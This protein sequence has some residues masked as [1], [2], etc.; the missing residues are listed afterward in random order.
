[1]T[2]DQHDPVPSSKATPTHGFI[3]A[4]VVLVIGLTIVHAVPYAHIKTVGLGVALFFAVCAMAGFA[5][6]IVGPVV[7]VYWLAR[8]KWGVLI[9]LLLCVGWG[10]LWHTSLGPQPRNLQRMERL[11]NALEAH[12]ATGERAPK[13]DELADA[14]DVTGA[15]PHGLASF[16]DPQQGAFV[17][18]Y[19]RPILYNRGIGGTYNIVSRGADGVQDG[20]ELEGDDIVRGDLI[21]VTINGELTENVTDA[22]TD[23]FRDRL[24]GQAPDQNTPGAGDPDP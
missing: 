21:V 13:Q 11:H 10:V 2:D 18:A 17:A 15:D 22:V 5:T 23:F 20:P 24:P 9:A 3:A 7:G 4:F 16:Y 12:K 19:G 14:L 8:R 1:M 6:P